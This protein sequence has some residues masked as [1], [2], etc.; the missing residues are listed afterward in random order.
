M[1]EEIGELSQ[2]YLNVS[3]VSNGKQKTWDDVREEVADCLIVALD[4]AWTRMHDEDEIQP[5]RFVDTAH[6]RGL[7][8]FRT[9]FTISYHL[10]LFIQGIDLYSRGSRHEIGLVVNQIADLA[11]SPLPDQVEMPTEELET[12]LLAEVNRKL[13]KWATN[14]ANMQ[15]VTDDV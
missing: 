9:A 12:Q 3:S 8:D 14:R 2:A 7:F 13:A 5:F 10:T 11:L 1:L 15:V 6:D 4:I